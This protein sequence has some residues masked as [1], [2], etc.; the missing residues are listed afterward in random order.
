[1]VVVVVAAAAAASDS[2]ELLE[3]GQYLFEPGLRELL[4]YWTVVAFAGCHHL[5]SDLVVS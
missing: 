1:M 5:G 3:P 2:G 4:G